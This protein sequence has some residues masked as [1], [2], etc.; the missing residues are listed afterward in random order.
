MLK[1]VD[2][3]FTALPNGEAQK[4][5]KNLNNK[6]ILID[7]AADFRLK[8]ATDYLKWY[9]IKH[10]APKLIKKSIYSLPELNN[11]NIKKYKIISCP[12]CYPTS[13]LLPLVPLINKNIVKSNNI[14]IDSKSGSQVQ[15]KIFTKNITTNF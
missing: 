11:Q 13:I 1:N 9:K 7:L 8:S 6:N 14:I 5:S 2:V 15:A 4:I 10:N 3:I 12:G